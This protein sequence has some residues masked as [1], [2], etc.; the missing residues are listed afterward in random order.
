MTDHELHSSSETV[1]WGHFDARLKPKLRVKSG[2]KVT[3][4]CV[5]GG[6][7]ILLRDVTD[8]WIH[9]GRPVANSQL[10]ARIAGKHSRQ[11]RFSN[12]LCPDRSRLFSTDPEVSEGTAVNGT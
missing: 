5:S 4:H 12:N 7:E 3:V 9:G 10:Y 11:I 1:H 2:D 8:A 6:P